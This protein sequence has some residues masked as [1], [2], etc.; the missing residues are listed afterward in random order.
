MEILNKT[1]DYVFGNLSWSLTV[2]PYK[3]VKIVNPLSGFTGVWYFVF[4]KQT[5]VFG[6]VYLLKWL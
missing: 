2:L 6:K 4:S 5:Q 3:I 1:Q